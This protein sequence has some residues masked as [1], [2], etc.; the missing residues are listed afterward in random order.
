MDD[1]LK[2]E[3]RQRYAAAATA[4][5]SSTDAAASDCCGS[6]AGCGPGDGFGAVLYGEELGGLPDAT[7]EASL[8]CGNPI[9]MAE[10]H[11]GETVLDLGSGAGIDVL[12]SARRVGP[13]GRAYGLDM[14]DEMLE[15]ARAN[16]AEAGADNVEFLKGDIE[17]VPL[18][19]ASVDV[20]LS[21]CVINLST[22]K[23]AVFDELAR[24]VRPGGRLA[25][26]DVVAEDGLSV[27]QRAE[28]GSYVGCIAGALSFAEY[29]E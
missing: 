24:V 11:A 18:P 4:A 20:V 17:D 5:S 9:A 16:A 23:P 13:S 25:I 12:L 3:V 14:T 28:R 22:D 6:Q 15:L 7:L 8:G 19:D 1:V 10:L 21:N 2:E 27:E 29:R 26:S